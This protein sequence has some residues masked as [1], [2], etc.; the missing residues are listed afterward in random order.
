MR[1]IPTRLPLFP[2][3]LPIVCLSATIASAQSTVPA[4]QRDDAAATAS[5]R[6]IVVADFN[7]DGWPDIATANHGPD[8][9][10]VL[11]SRGA[12]GGYTQ[13]PFISVSGGPFDVA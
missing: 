1:T 2:A 11:L 13:M 4:F 8:G 9:V 10:A 7:R 12:A 3:L 5:G 6:G